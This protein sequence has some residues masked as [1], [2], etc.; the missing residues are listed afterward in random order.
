MHI[1]KKIVYISKVEQDTGK[2]EKQEQRSRS[3]LFKSS[4]CSKLRFHEPEVSNG[5]KIVCISNATHDSG[6][7]VWEDSLV[8]QFIGSSPKFSQIQGDVNQLWGR[9]GRIEII[10]LGSE[11]FLFKFENKLM[12]IWVLEGRP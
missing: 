3:S 10:E 9:K 5:K 11:N 7:A 1:V 4:S 8:A 2:L 6:F 12:K